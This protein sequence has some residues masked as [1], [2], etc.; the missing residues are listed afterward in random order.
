M[1]DTDDAADD[2]AIKPSNCSKLLS[3][4]DTLRTWISAIVMRLETSTHSI[5]DIKSL[6]S[7]ESA[8][9]DGQENLPAQHP[10]H[11]TDTAHCNPAH[12]PEHMAALC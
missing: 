5:F 11:S 9:C 1:F 10:T 12:P 3:F 6:A 7:A 8:T 2:L 4:T